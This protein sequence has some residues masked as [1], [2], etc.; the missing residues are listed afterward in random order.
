[1]HY[2]DDLKSN[3][4]ATTTQTNDATSPSAAQCNKSMW[5]NI[6]K[7]KKEKQKQKQ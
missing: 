6:S 4:A 2:K 5:P 3:Q 7:S 1:M